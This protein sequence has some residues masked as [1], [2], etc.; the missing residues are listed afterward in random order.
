MTSCVWQQVS[1]WS[2]QGWVWDLLF[3]CVSL[4]PH[5]ESVVV[6]GTDALNLAKSNSCFSIL[7]MLSV[8]VAFN[9]VPLSL[10]STSP[11]SWLLK[12]S[13]TLW[14]WLL[15]PQLFFWVLCADLFTRLNLSILKCPRT[16]WAIFPS[17]ICSSFSAAGPQYHQYPELS[18]ASLSN[19][20]PSIGFQTGMYSTAYWTQPPGSWLHFFFFLDVSQPKFLFPCLTSWHKWIIHTLAIYWMSTTLSLCLLGIKVLVRGYGEIYI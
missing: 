13:S 19:P 4:R 20:D 15:A 6:K 16:H 1:Q 7:I 2:S 14:L 18:Q 3:I 8:S 12:T 11:F 9:L 17:C 10:S 5:S